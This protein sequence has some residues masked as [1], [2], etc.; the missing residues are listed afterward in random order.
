VRKTWFF[1]LLLATGTA[2]GADSYKSVKEIPI[3]G[4]GGWD[5]LSIDAKARRLYVTHADEIVIV[6]LDKNTVAGE[7]AGTI[8]VHG[9]ASH[10][11]LVAG[12]RV[13]AGK[14]RS[15]SLT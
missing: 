14:T 11:N 1:I 12:F 6:D 3:S 13:M 9:F 10:R 4:A 7:I 5:Y 2:L 15:A 8:G